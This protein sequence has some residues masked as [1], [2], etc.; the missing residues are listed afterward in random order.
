MVQ[1]LHWVFVNVCTTFY[2]IQG[3]KIWCNV[4]GDVNINIKFELIS[5][6]AKKFCWYYHGYGNASSCWTTSY[7]F[8]QYYYFY[9]I[10]LCIKFLFPN[11]PLS[12]SQ[13]S[14]LHTLCQTEEEKN[15]KLCRYIKIMMRNNLN[16]NWQRNDATSTEMY[17]FAECDKF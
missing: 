7:L 17:V 9:S 6:I 13:N 12:I 15:R 3:N 5:C 11:K 2:A 8:A 10:T 16:K 4:S 1:S 14:P